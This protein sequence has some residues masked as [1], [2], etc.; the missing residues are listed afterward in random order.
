MNIEQKLTEA[1]NLLCSEDASY[2]ETEPVRDAM[3]LLLEVIRELDK[4]TGQQAS[5]VPKSFKSVEDQLKPM[6]IIPLEPQ[7]AYKPDITCDGGMQ[8]TSFKL[9]E[10]SEPID[11]YYVGHT[12]QVG[13][14]R[15]QIKDYDGSTKVAT[16]WGD[17]PE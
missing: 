12:L 9:P 11:S 14:R 16:V 10:E 2:G 7:P 5:F 15:Y 13:D 4:R 17:K 3:F 1:T 6:H 8:P